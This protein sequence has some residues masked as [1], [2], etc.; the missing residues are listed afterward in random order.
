MPLYPRPAEL[1]R[2][3]SPPTGGPA[4]TSQT[5]TAGRVLLH[6]VIVPY[7]CLIDGVM[8]CV[9]AATAGNVIGGLVGPVARSADSPDGA[10]VVAQSASTAQG[11]INTLQFLSWTAVLVQPGIY[12]AALE[13]DNAT[14]TCNRHGSALQ[15]TGLF[16]QYDR[17]GGYGA[18]TSPTPATTTGSS[19]AGLRL[20]IA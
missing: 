20:R 9:G 5:F 2:W 15:A 19:P 14:G 4:S 8:Y 12:Y 7:A 16:A 13:G 17:S 6:Q 10:V 1:G 11:A 18:L 3:L